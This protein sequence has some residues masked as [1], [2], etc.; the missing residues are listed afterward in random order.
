M[1]RVKQI[2]ITNLKEVPHYLET[3]AD[4]HHVQWSYLNPDRTLAERI[5]RMRENLKPDFIPTTFVAAEDKLLGT[6]GIIKHDMDT[7][8]ELSPWL[9]GVYVAPEF[10]SRGI[11]SKLVLHVMEQAR[12]NNIKTLY[13]YTTDREAFYARLGWSTFE[14]TNYHG[15]PVTIMS[16]NL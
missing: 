9:E 2:K 10:R 11:G 4:W 14:K 1:V 3:L 6:A 7:R 5:D 8:K 16:V 13:L 12:D 15:Y